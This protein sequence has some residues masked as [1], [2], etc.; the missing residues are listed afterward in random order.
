[1]SVFG[2]NQ[3]I[4]KQ[5]LIKSNVVQLEKKT[6]LEGTI[7]FFIRKKQEAHEFN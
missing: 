3:Q 2:A 4:E 1:M 6:N 7:Q 5:S